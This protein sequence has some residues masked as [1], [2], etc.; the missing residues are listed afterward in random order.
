MGVTIR[1]ERR[2]LGVGDGEIGEPTP[3]D[4]VVGAYVGRFSTGD[5]EIS[6]RR[7]NP[8]PRRG[9]LLNRQRDKNR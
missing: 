2:L 3:P 6:E 9:L 1:G 5:G 4:P 7:E 8:F